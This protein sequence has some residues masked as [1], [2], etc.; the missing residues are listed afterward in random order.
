[1]SNVPDE[2]S[3]SP[4][5]VL[6]V[7]CEADEPWASWI[8][9]T[10]EDHGL[11]ARLFSWTAVGSD[12]AGA[13]AQGLAASDRCAVILSQAFLTLTAYSASEWRAALED[14][15]HLLHRLVPVVV[16]RAS[17]PELLPVSLREKIVDL[18]EVGEQAALG[19]VVPAFTGKA[20]RR[21]VAARTAW[22]RARTR[23]PADEPA[24]WS[25]WIPKRNFLFTGRERELQR[26]R[27]QLWSAPAGA[28]T[29]ALTGLGGVGKSQIA[30]EYAYRFQSEYEAVW[31][32]RA[33]RS[34]QARQDLLALSGELG[35]PTGE[36]LHSDLE[37]AR[38][39]LRKD[40]AG[41]RWLIIV[42]DARSPDSVE[43]VLP[44]FHGRTGHVIITSTDEN[45]AGTAA[46]Q[47]IEPMDGA[48]SLRYLQA[49][50]QHP[51]EE[52]ETLAEFCAGLPAAM[53]VAA[54]HLRESP[55]AIETYLRRVRENTLAPFGYRPTGYP[56][57]LDRTFVAALDDV[58]AASPAAG[59]LL[60]LLSLMASTPLPVR[61]F[62]SLP[63][64]GA[65]LPSPHLASLP[66]MLDNASTEREIVNI[67]RSHSLARV[68]LS[69]DEPT[70]E[71]H[72]VP[73]R[74]IEHC[75]P[76]PQLTVYR[77]LI[78]LMLRDRDI[79][80]ARTAADWHVMLDIWRNLESS[81]A[82]S[83]LR[84]A[85]DQSTRSL[86]LHV[87]R[88]LMIWGESAHSEHAARALLDTWTPVL[89]EKHTDVHEATLELANCLRNQGRA[90]ESLELDRRLSDQIGALR[91]ARPET[92]V[93][94]GLN[95][96][97]DLR[98]L[99]RFADAR[100]V[101][102]RTRDLAVDTF[103][104]ADRLSLMAR[105]NAALS[106]LLL[107]E[108]RQALEQDEALWRDQRRVRGDADRA[109]VSTLVRMARA[110]QDLGEYRQAVEMQEQTLQRSRRLFG[111]DSVI[112]LF[113]TVHLASAQRVVGDFTAAW[114]SM[115]TVVEPMRR[116]LGAEHPDR[117]MALAELT[118]ALRCL[119]RYEEAQETGERSVAM[120]VAVNGEHHPATAIC[121][122]KLGLV[123]LARADGFAAFPLFDAAATTLEAALPEDHP[124][125]LVARIN[126]ASARWQNQELTLADEEEQRLQGPV[127]R[128][129]GANHPWALAWAANRVTTL[130]ALDLPAQRMRANA[131]WRETVDA[132][133]RTLGRQHPDAQVAEARK[134]RVL[135][136]V[137][138]PPM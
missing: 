63:R 90:R 33:T 84:C 111:Q 118:S 113:A 98:R 44:R 48:T 97:G 66:G 104:P 28:G 75:I 41:R 22:G 30:L 20:P 16:D 102:E 37:V 47:G 108:P 40:A 15:E 91:E 101:D 10:L 34:A 9:E 36:A 27:D 123:H 110:H 76:E 105:N 126:R 77:H 50:L 64:L 96:G 107:W 117:I 21:T 43:A 87:I 57:P 25:P 11:S 132:Y 134:D 121:R 32:I 109:T 106:S 120:S 73:Q 2:P 138:V 135:V 35:F 89:G 128:S 24:V 127:L 112:A 1:M 131:Q 95:L 52:L 39:A 129:L 74:V 81:Q 45:W 86:M 3:A 70:I 100:E 13:V 59:E 51:D 49:R 92:R 7:H 79:I 133:A 19:R 72:R 103:G 61:L 54:A 65:D 8:A 31:F 125:T 68:G 42:D 93:R 122:N 58:T 6:I 130:D 26:L 124:H 136:D 12:L 23:F 114:R 14:S 29:V 116:V 78:H 69:E 115:Q 17:I 137:D 53:E 46:T 67:I 82:W 55:Q 18:S 4:H 71:M 60:K 119:R 83:C 56:Q 94:V 38:E 80:A 88:A 62:G 85:Q 5:A 99:G